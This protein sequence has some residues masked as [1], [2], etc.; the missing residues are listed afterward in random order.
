[1]TIQITWHLILVIVISIVL[2]IGIF[3][4]EE[5][6]LGFSNGFYGILLIALWL[7]MIVI[8]FGRYGI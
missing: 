6:A 7:F 4:E 8:L 1:M 5:S 2:I 3:K